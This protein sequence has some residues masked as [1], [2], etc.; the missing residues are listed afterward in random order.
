MVI[1]KSATD[2]FF[3]FLGRDQLCIE[4]FLH[5]ET[6]QLSLKKS[7]FKNFSKFRVIC[8]QK[9]GN[10]LRFRSFHSAECKKKTTSISHFS[11]V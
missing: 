9:P 10:Q 5:R 3:L 7:G 6:L 1:I 2:Y 11:P 8:T 4:N